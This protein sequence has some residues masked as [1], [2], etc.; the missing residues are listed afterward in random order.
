[1]SAP[2]G[3][4]KLEVWK[5]TSTTEKH[6]KMRLIISAR[7]VVE[8]RLA[9]QGVIRGLNIKKHGFFYTR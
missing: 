5:E 6:K 2:N 9:V 7:E 4:L 8:S 1:M 3:Y